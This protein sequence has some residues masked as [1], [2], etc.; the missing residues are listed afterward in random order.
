MMKSFTITQGVYEEEYK[1]CQE[2]TKHQIV[3]LAKL[4]WISKK[5]KGGGGRDR[6]NAA[7]LH[8]ALDSKID[9]HSLD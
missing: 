5:K 7:Q 2:I 6:Q 3:T 8:A 4:T 1:N 9:K